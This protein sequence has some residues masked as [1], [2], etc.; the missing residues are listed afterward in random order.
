M[1]V[2]KSELTLAIAMDKAVRES[3]QADFRHNEFKERRIKKALFNVLNDKD[4][5][6]RAY[7]IAAAQGEY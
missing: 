1:A 7:I 2:K 6:E 5:V 4:M 3:K